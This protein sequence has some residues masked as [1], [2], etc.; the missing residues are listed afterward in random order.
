[1]TSKILRP[2]G[3][4]DLLDEMFD[5][6]KRNFLLFV[7]ISGVVMLPYT[8]F[9][10]L[11]MAPWYKMMGNMQANPQ[12]ID[13]MTGLA[14]ML[15]GMGLVIILGSFM[16]VIAT[17][18]TTWA[19]SS[20][21]LGRKPS[22]LEAYN[23]VISKTIPFA[24]TGL[25]VSVALVIG[26]MCC[27]LPGIVGLVFLAF[28]PAVMVIENRAYIDGISRSFQL[29]A[30]DFWRIFVYGLVAGIL[31]Y[32]ISIIFALPVQIII[33]TNPSR[34]VQASMVSQII[35]GIGNTILV[36]LWVIGLVLLYYDV[37]VRREGFDI[38]LLAESM[39]SGDAPTSPQ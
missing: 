23:A 16:Q 13:P 37:R 29:A 38:Q 25:I 15:V 22:I 5:L 27:V 20:C 18:A 33:M 11:A 32:A 39:T 10:A 1:M 21:Y 36:P 19:V 28:V 2:L 14:P 7:G 17:A 34:L 31:I 12:H 35:Q 26:F 9:L 4:G 30:S 8:F 24:V 6:Y 3:I